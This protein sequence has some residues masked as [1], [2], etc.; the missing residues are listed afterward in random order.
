MPTKIV[1]AAAAVAACTCRAEAIMKART[2]AFAMLALASG[3][4]FAAHTT[5]AEIAAGTGLTAREVSMVLGSSTG[6]AEFTTTYSKVYARLHRALGEER[7]QQ[8]MAAN[9]IKPRVQLAAHLD[10]QPLITRRS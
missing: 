2:C 10:R 8:L 3:S 9:G 1:D 7:L 5:P 4:A 6:Y